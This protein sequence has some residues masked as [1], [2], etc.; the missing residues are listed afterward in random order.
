MSSHFTILSDIPG[1]LINQGM[2][3]ASARLADTMH[4]LSTGYR[5][6]TARDDPSGLI[7]SE[8]FQSD[9][10]ATQSLMKNASYG[11]TVFSVADSGL[12]ELT[13]LVQEANK[14][15]F[16][17]NVAQDG[18]EVAATVMEGLVKSFDFVVQTTRFGET[19]LLD[20][21]YQNRKFRLGLDS[22]DIETVSIRKM[23]SSAVGQSSTTAKDSTLF[24]DGSAVH[25]SDLAALLTDPEGI[26]NSETSQTNLEVAEQVVKQA[27]DDVVKE[28]AKVGTTQKY[29]FDTAS[30]RLQAELTGLTS[31]LS[32]V[33]DLDLG[34]AE[35]DLVR[36]QLL[37][38]T[39]SALVQLN[40]Q[41]R[42][43]I[44]SLVG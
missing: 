4:K 10:T 27:L 7:V 38:A 34:Q 22:H 44:A 19:A 40:A 15:V 28:R 29:T 30:E 17:S 11:N 9:I 39:G 20:G 35:L 36:D 31:A 41:R 14:I 1:M 2:R 32:E 33:K 25:F 37:L 3:S 13:N 5:I 18:V 21:S 42:A 6:N 16:D 24:A 8:R 12:A 26:F 43:M 23:N